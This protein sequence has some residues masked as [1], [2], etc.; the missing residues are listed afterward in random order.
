[1]MIVD[2]K[3]K[4]TTSRGIRAA[5]GTDATHSLIFDTLADGIADAIQH[6]LV[7]PMFRS[8]ISHMTVTSHVPVF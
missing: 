7:F 3:E 4:I 8:V 2:L 6:Q 5:V 1:M